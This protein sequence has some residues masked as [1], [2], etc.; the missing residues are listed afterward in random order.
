MVW[1]SKIDEIP[2]SASHI[3]KDIKGITFRKIGDATNALFKLKKGDYK[4]K[5]LFVVTPDESKMLEGAGDSPP[6]GLLYVAT[7]ASKEGHDLKFY[8]L[9][10][11][12]KEE[13]LKDVLQTTAALLLQGLL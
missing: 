1:I 2:M 10:H 13:F 8:D 3:D 5:S 4:M 7:S 12:K 11:I 6:L 9:N